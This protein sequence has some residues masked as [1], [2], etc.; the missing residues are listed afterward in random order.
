M[1]WLDRLF[2]MV[3]RKRAL[4]NS[5]RNLMRDK[6]KISGYW[7]PLCDKKR[8]DDV[9][10]FEKEVFLDKYGE[11]KTINL[12]NQLGDKTI[13]E[14]VEVGNDKKISVDN[15][16]LTSDETFYCNDNVDWIIYCSHEKTITIG[17]KILLDKFKT[18]WPELDKYKDPW[19]TKN[20]GSA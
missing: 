6:F 5:T 8:I 10:Y 7:Y 17:G 16:D 1:G 20:G 14:I 18:D 12:L 4:D 19:A 13:N 3:F 9:E 15:L 11:K 2:K